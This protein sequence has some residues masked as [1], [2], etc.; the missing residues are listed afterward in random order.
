MTG[1]RLQKARKP[2]LLSRYA[3]TLGELTFRRQTELAL[4]AAK[5]ESEAASRAKSAFLATMTHELRTPLNAI[6]GFS[7]LIR[8]RDRSE[9]SDDKS[10]DYA[11]QIAEAGRHLNEVISDVLDLSKIESGTLQLAIDDTDIAELVEMAVASQADAIAAKHQHLTMHLAPDLPELP[12]DARRI[13]QA[14]VKLLS[15][16]S[17]FTDD[18]GAIDVLAER[19]GDD[20]V[21]IRISDTGIGMTPDQ[22]SIALQPF[23]QVQS[24]YSRTQEGTGLGLP[25][26]SGLI[27]CH[28]GQ[29]SLESEPGVGTT[30]IIML[31]SAAPPPIE[32]TGKTDSEAVR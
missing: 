17:K 6:I 27:H 31:R 16:A 28:G 3:Q 18:H 7:D 26:A 23:G 4:M 22:M 11:G 29:L 15:N 25:I 1:V 30:A 2:T 9:S 21:I 12:L 24:T 13:R 8:H 32:R 5:A 19:A 10:I 20:H 14:L